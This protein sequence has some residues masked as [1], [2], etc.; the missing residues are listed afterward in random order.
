MN[1]QLDFV[2]VTVP[3]DKKGIAGKEGD[4]TFEIM[5]SFMN[6]ETP[7]GAK[8]N[9]PEL[10]KSRRGRKP[11]GIPLEERKIVYAKT[12]HDRDVEK[13][14]QAKDIKK[15]GDVTTRRMY[16]LEHIIKSQ[17]LTWREVADRAGLTQQAVSWI[18]VSDDTKLQKV[19]EIL[20]PLKIDIT[21]TYISPSDNTIRIDHRWED[22][23]VV[24]FIPRI[25][26]SHSSEKI[27]EE[28]MQAKD[29]LYFLS[30]YL[31]DNSITLQQLS[32]KVGISMQTLRNCYATKNIRISQIYDIAEAYG[33][34]VRWQLSPVVD[35]Y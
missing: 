17:G 32:D 18:M 1:V 35:E 16:F 8:M 33:L 31:F 21:P 24:G 14:Q 5:E 22:F 23:E 13:R 4:G 9:N 27:I 19:K 12:Q 25:Q 15:S 6:I 2:S 26:R 30:R 29:N 11:S 10:N 7:K 34:R 3:E 20:A 28:S